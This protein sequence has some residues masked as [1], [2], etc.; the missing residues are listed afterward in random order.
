L[1]RVQD[2]HPGEPDVT[3]AKTG[4]ILGIA[5]TRAFGDGL[6]KW[7]LD[8]VKECHEKFFYRAPRPGYKT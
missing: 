3:N 8:V 6:W 1:V 4:R 2:A 7:P 5:V